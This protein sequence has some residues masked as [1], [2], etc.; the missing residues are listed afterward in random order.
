MSQ[1]NDVGQGL[2]TSRR[3]RSANRWLL[4]LV[5]ILCAFIVILGLQTYRIQQQGAVMANLT[6]N[7]YQRDFHDLAGHMDEITGQ[8][9][10]VLSVSSREQLSLSLSTLWRQTFAA[11]ANLGG[12]PLAMIQLNQ[13]EKF[14]GD[15][16]D[17]VYYLLWRTSREADTLKDSE[18][19]YILELYQRSQALSSALEKISYQIVEEDLRLVDLQNGLWQGDDMKD[20]TI[21]DGL[22]MLET[23]LEDYPELNI[24]SDLQEL[25]GSEESVPGPPNAEGKD[26]PSQGGDLKGGNEGNRAVDGAGTGSADLTGENNNQSKEVNQIITEET[27]INNALDFWLGPEHVGFGGRIAYE[28]GGDLPTYG[29]E[30]Y[31]LRGDQA[32]ANVDIVK[33][34]G[35][36]LWAMSIPDIDWPYGTKGAADQ[37]ADLEETENAAEVSEENL[38]VLQMIQGNRV[39]ISLDQGASLCLGFLSDR[40]FPEMVLSHSQID[41]GY[42]IYT[43]VPMQE[44]VRLYPDQIKMQV[45]LATAQITGYEGTPFYRH[46]HLRQLPAVNVSKEKVQTLLSPYLKVSGIHLALIENDWNQ[47]ILTWEVRAK[48]GMESFALFYDTEHAIEEKIIRLSK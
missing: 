31:T 2:I 8:L 20:N 32:V 33:K 27:A 45:D 40:D 48:L 38:R 43:F 12:L 17:S 3:G 44:G 18:K 29:V 34:D 24:T 9:A 35:K 19:E 21:I 14:L 41:E 10:Q 39:N 13:T 25:A 5:L 30:I 22:G 46:H 42:G 6:E 7:N 11:Q 16:A 28:S 23:Q 36:V 15:T 1:E 47:E 26:L 4:F 37:K